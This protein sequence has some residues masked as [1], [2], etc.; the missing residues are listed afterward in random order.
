MALL[1]SMQS[2]AETKHPLP[3]TSM[4]LT[5]GAG[6]PPVGQSFV[7]CKL[8]FTNGELQSSQKEIHHFV[9][10]VKDLIYTRYIKIRIIDGQNYTDKKKAFFYHVGK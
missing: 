1:W 7:L 6:P 4:L 8:R 9:L 3:W 2:F 5:D 10:N